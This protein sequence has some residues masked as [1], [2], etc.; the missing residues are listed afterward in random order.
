MISEEDLA[1]VNI[2]LKENGLEKFIEHVFDNEFSAPKEFLYIEKSFC[3]IKI[4]FEYQNYNIIINKIFEIVEELEP[5]E[6]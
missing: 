5:Y 6:Q 4:Y 2:I 3:C 1:Y